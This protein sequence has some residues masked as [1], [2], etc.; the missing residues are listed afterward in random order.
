MLMHCIAKALPTDAKTENITAKLSP[1]RTETETSHNN[2]TEQ[3]KNPTRGGT[4]LHQG[5]TQ[6]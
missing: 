2:K 3:N 5:T 1:F 4:P 6:K